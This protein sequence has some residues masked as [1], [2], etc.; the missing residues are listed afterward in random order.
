MNMKKILAAASASVLALSAMSVM[1][2]AEDLTYK[3]EVGYI[4]SWTDVKLVDESKKNLEGELGK[5]KAGLKGEDIDT[6]T[7]TGNDKMTEWCV[8]GDFADGWKQ[9]DSAAI[10]DMTEAGFFK[11]AKSVTIKGS[12][13]NWAK[14]N[15]MCIK[16]GVNAADDDAVVTVTVKTKSG[17]TATST[18]ATSTPATST[19]DDK[20]NVPTGVGGVAA[21]VG[22]AVVAAGAMIVAKNRK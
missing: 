15:D 1:A 16:L 18:P 19:S 3:M 21:V 4:D 12:D 11:G 5:I 9:S 22:V 6:I 2:F 20:T 8:G 7:F 14:G 13:L 10:G 17:E